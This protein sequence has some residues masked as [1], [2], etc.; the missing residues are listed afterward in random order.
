MVYLG[1][2]V[3]GF[4]KQR[5]IGQAGVLDTARYRAFIAMEAGVSVKD[6]QAMVLGGHGDDMV[7]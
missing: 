6:I 1:Y 5:V 7:P 2:K 4:P 3:S